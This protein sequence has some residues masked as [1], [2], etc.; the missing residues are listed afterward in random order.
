MELKKSWLRPTQITKKWPENKYGFSENLKEVGDY[1]ETFPI[2]YEDCVKIRKAAHLWA[3]FHKY[4]V[5]TKCIKQWETG[6]YYIRVTLT[7]KVR[8]RDYK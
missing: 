7:A 6:L 8:I 4:R 5:V 3:W 2:P 1:V